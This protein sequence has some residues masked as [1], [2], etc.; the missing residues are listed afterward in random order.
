MIVV[1]AEN[2]IN[3]ADQ[4]AS[5]YLAVRAGILEPDNAIDP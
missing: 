4:F 2:A 5:L 3:A 1:M